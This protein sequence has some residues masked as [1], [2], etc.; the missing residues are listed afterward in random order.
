MRLNRG[1][2]SEK[3]MSKIAVDVVLLPPEAVTEAAIEA[4][5]KLVREFGE[6]I[7]LN[8]DDCLPHISLTMGCLDENDISV[9]A[10]VLEG[11]AKDTPAM[12]LRIKGVAVSENAVGEK[13][14]C[15]EVAKT[16]RLQELHESVLEKLAV[17]LSSD[18]TAD[19]IYDGAGISESTLM[20]IKNYREKS[21]FAN[22][23]PHITIGYGQLGEVGIGP[24]FTA[25]KLALCH[26]G[27]HCTCRKVLVSVELG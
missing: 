24:D 22:F 17:Y 19:M 8:K 11:I 18:V 4:N 16:E 5:A 27:N 12:E 23:F 9:A 20:W 10:G 25:S 13:V 6:K 14:S 26:L 7:V 21:S 3:D 15:F 1:S 2:G